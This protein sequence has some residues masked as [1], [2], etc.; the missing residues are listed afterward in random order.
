MLGSLGYPNSNPG[1]C[2]VSRLSF[3]PKV[4]LYALDAMLGRADD[5]FDIDSLFVDGSPPPPKPGTPAAQP[6]AA[7]AG[8]SRAVPPPPVEDDPE[9]DDDDWYIK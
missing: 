8:G 1:N 3:E 4:G 6:A 7:A 9:D 5:E 2:W